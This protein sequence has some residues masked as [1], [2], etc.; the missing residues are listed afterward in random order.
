[1]FSSNIHT[2]SNV[3]FRLY[4]ALY[5]VINKSIL[6]AA[7]NEDERMKRLFNMDIKSTSQ[8]AS[9]VVARPEDENLGIRLG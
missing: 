7:N 3:K 5:A 6:I 9:A 1:M 2:Y 8:S 4:P